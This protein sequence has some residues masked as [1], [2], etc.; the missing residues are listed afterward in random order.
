MPRITYNTTTPSSRVPPYCLVGYVC[1]ES[2]GEMFEVT[3]VEETPE[4]K[5][6]MDS[7]MSWVLPEASIRK[8]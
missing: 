5:Q 2:R 4:R 6:L 1:V 8:I 7:L 3:G